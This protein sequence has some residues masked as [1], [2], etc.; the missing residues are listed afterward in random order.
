M[1][2]RELHAY[3]QGPDLA[4]VTKWIESVVTDL[5]RKETID[6]SNEIGQTLIKFHGKRDLLLL[7]Q[8]VDTEWLELTV[9]PRV[10][11]SIFAEWDHIK[12]G[13]RLVDDL[14]GITLV[15]CCGIYTDPLSD[16][17]VRI[18]SDKME[19]VELPATVYEPLDESMT[20]LIKR[21]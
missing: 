10:R 19:L 2:T 1:E 9:R 3:I 7:E 16:Q 17:I 8:L 6:L 11:D 15:D 18:S 12:L 20:Q 5:D 4:A 21:R 14:G 13:E